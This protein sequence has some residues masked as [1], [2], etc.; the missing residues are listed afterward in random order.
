M[1]PFHLAIQVRNLEEA[2][3]FYTHYLQCSTGRSSKTWLDLNLYGHQLVCHVNP[4]IGDDGTLPVV[5]NPVDS[6]GVPIPHFGVVLQMQEW[7][8]LADNLRTQGVEFVIEPTI[9]FRGKPGE[10]ATMFFYDPSGN[11]LEFKAFSNIEE[12]LFAT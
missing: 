10:Q 11:A 8:D 4:Q 6:H 1:Q 7:Q 5:H 12:Q 9:R 3:H 2:R